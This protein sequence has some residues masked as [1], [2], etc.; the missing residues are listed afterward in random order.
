MN[1]FF[2]N[3]PPQ[4]EDAPA[5]LLT[6]VKTGKQHGRHFYYYFLSFKLKEFYNYLAF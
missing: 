5:I 3:F 6:S 4:Q 1:S 2:S